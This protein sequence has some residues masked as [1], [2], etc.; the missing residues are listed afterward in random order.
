[1]SEEFS[2]AF[3]IKM[4]NSIKITFTVGEEAEVAPMVWVGGAVFYPP[5]LFS[6]PIFGGLTMGTILEGSVLLL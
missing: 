4:V 1:M 2:P 3:I 6:F 5:P